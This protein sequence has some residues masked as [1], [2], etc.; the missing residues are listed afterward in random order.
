MVRR[1]VQAKKRRSGC[2]AAPKL[3][4]RPQTAKATAELVGRLLR[5][6]DPSLNGCWL[7]SG[8]RDSKGYG[9]IKLDGR[10]V[11]VHRLA[12][13]VFNGGQV[14][15]GLTVH[16]RCGNP[17]CLNPE[18]LELLTNSDNAAEGNRRRTC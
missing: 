14:P 10:A 15:D 4:I 9:Q 18:H 12:Y 13:A 16:H 7:W 2:L 8:H 5:R 17:G 6:T 11:W 1:S 3:L